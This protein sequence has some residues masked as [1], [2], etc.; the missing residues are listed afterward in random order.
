MLLL[1]NQVTA[2]FLSRKDLRFA[3]TVSHLKNVGG[4]LEWIRTLGLQA[5]LLHS[6]V[7]HLAGVQQTSGCLEFE[8]LFEK[9][10][11]V[12]HVIWYL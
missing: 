10:S 9:R 8:N 2:G 6:A 4:S 11:F 1:F 5:V 3:I 12:R 7:G